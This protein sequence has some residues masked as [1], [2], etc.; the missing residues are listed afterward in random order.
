MGSEAYKYFL[1]SLSQLST[2]I[3]ESDLFLLLSYRYFSIIIVGTSW[4]W[5]T[6][7]TDLEQNSHLSELPLELVLIILQNLPDFDSLFA[8]IRTCQRLYACFEGNASWIITSIS[9]NIHQRA[10][11]LDHQDYQARP[12]PNRGSCFIFRQLNFAIENNYIH[13]DLSYKCLRTP[14]LSYTIKDLKR[15][16][17]HLEENWHLLSNTLTDES[18]IF[19]DISALYLEQ[20]GSRRSKH[21]A[22]RSR[23]TSKSTSQ[24]RRQTTT[25]SH[26]PH[27]QADQFYVY[28]QGPNKKIPSFSIK[29]KA[30]HK[31]S[32]AH[33]KAGLQDIELDR[34][35]RYQIDKSPKDIFHRVIAAVVTQLSNYMYNSG[36]EYSYIAPG[37]ASIFLHV[38]H[39]RPS[40][41]LYCL[42][43]PKEDIG[44]TTG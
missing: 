31:L 15:Y 22:R 6:T 37:E 24:T 23:D 26:R 7:M 16:W 12:F 33:I 21:L 3:A 5:A 20:G 25:P 8:A 34:I 28:N 41:I 35:V 38:P 30:P 36:N 29:Y 14:G 13:R 11:Q 10:I 44:N 17:F 32:L 9:S 19:T 43:V 18:K 1:G 40:T 42:S 27:P 2:K 4:N 39:N